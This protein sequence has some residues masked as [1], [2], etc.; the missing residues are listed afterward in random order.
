MEA[1]IE[2]RDA[3]PPRQI[4]QLAHHR[5]RPFVMT[6]KIPGGDDGNRQNLRVGDSRPHITAMPQAF[7][8][9]V[10]HDES[11]YYRASDRRLLLAMMLV[12][13]PR[14]CQRCRWSSTSDQG[15]NFCLA[16]LE[17]SY[18]PGVVSIKY[19]LLMILSIVNSLM[20]L[21]LFKIGIMILMNS[22]LSPLSLLFSWRCL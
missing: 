14:S 13:R 16:V 6:A 9:R 12:G 3:D 15:M 8:Q 11:G 22:S 10:N 7:H 5:C 2:A 18:L 19:P 21:S 17:I 4:A 1:A 20:V